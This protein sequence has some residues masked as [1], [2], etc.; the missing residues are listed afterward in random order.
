MKKDKA[1][2]LQRICALIQENCNNTV[3]R[4]TDGRFAK[5]IL[6]HS[7]EGG[8]LYEYEKNWEYLIINSNGNVA[9]SLRKSEHKHKRIC[10][11]R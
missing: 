2:E 3:V 8:F 1:A 7:S 9:G 5:G 4:G 10:D 11:D 6:I